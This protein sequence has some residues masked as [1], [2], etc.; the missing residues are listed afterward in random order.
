MEY[1]SKPIMA[2][3]IASLL[4]LGAAPT[5][6]QIGDVRAALEAGNKE[7]VAAFTRGD[8]AGVAGV[9]T[10]SA[11]VFPPQGDIVQGREA[12][13]RFWQGVIDSGVKGVSL[14]T[15][16]VEVYGDMA[17]EVGTYNLTGDGGKAL[18]AGKYVVV[19]KTEDGKWRV[20]RDIWNTSMPPSKP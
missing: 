20:H 11:Q 6:A 14:A 16:E 17:Y 13:A 2:F 19:W 3:A 5:F 8:G 12:I 4:L 18:D 10:T 7:W 15:L 1:V 9:Y